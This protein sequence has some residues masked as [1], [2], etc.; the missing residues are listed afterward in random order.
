[1]KQPSIEWRHA[2]RRV[3]LIDHVEYFE[4]LI[5]VIG[6]PV[7][8]RVR[9]VEPRCGVFA[10]R[11]AQAIVVIVLVARGQH[12]AV[13]GIEREQQPVEEGEGRLAQFT[14]IG[15][16][17]RAR[18]LGVRRLQGADEAGKHGL[19]NCVRQ[20]LADF[21]FPIFA[22]LKSNVMQRFAIGVRPESAVGEKQQEHFQRVVALFFRARAEQVLADAGNAKRG[23]QINFE[24]IRQ[25][26][27]GADKRK[28]PLTPVGQNAPAHTAVRLHFGAGQIAH[29]LRHWR[30]VTV[31]PDVKRHIPLL[32]FEQKVSVPDAV[33][34]LL[35]GIG[36]LPVCLVQKQESVG[37]IQIA[38]G[39]A[40]LDFAPPA[41]LL[42]HGIDEAIFSF[43][44]I[45]LA[46]CGEGVEQRCKFGLGCR[47]FLICQRG[48][49]SRLLDAFVE[50]V[51]GEKCSEHGASESFA[52]GNG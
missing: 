51:A 33:Q 7:R 17:Q 24:K 10:H 2:N 44:L 45:R 12:V 9:L 3:A 23:S 39:Y 20:A 5:V 4:A 41:K 46:A 34:R 49:C 1:M 8:Q 31:Y 30:R 42:C 38:F 6:T 11:H 25:Q 26:R 52:V 35:F 19:E 28:P 16:R 40:V 29:Q 22:L 18:R 14:E 43:S 15:G 13:F 50:K 36:Q 32:G 27:G 47:Q 48:P 21:L 37:N